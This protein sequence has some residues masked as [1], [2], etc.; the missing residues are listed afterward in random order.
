VLLDPQSL[1]EGDILGT[2]LAHA[3]LRN[4]RAG[5]GVTVDP[6]SGELINV[7]IP[8]TSLD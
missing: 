3:H 4:R 8:E 7:Q 5:Q 1:M 6:R 2:R